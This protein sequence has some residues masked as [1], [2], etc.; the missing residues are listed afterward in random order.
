MVGRIVAPAVVNGREIIAQWRRGVYR[1]CAYLASPDCR[2][3][4]TLLQSSVK[5]LELPMA[6]ERHE[7]PTIA[8]RPPSG[9]HRQQYLLG[10]AQGIF[11][12]PWLQWRPTLSV[13]PV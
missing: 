13:S 9:L 8:S 10:C 11:A 6:C 4:A 5:P 1:R 3:T 7:R 2:P 12:G